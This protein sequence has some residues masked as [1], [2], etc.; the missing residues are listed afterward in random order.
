[1]RATFIGKTLTAAF[2]LV[3]MLGAF[4]TNA[5]S[6]TTQAW[7]RRTMITVDV[8][9][10]VPGT[11]LPAGTYV[12]RLMVLKGT[13]TVVQIFNKGETQLFA[14]VIGVSAFRPRSPLPQPPMFH[15]NEAEPGSPAP[16]HTWY[17]PGQS[18]IEF[19]YPKKS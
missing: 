3:L 11:S 5:T 1:M 15:F 12:I 18:G 9:W 10:Q 7:D 8:P 14:T 6:Q 4:S 2:V 19:I 13:R 16:L 17:Y